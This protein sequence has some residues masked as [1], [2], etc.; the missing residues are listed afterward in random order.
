MTLGDKIQL[1]VF[2]VCGI[3]V[4][5]G[6]GYAIGDPKG[7]GFFGLWLGLLLGP[8][9]WIVIGLLGREGVDQEREC[10]ECLGSVPAA[11]RKCRHCGSDLPPVSQ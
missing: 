7:R 10:P 6:I 9:G 4:F 1:L 2:I 5:G 8:I 3:G 11:A